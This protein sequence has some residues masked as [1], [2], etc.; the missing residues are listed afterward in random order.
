MQRFS[1]QSVFYLLA[2]EILYNERDTWNRM[3][4]GEEEAFRTIFH[5]YT[6][7][8]YAA[9]LKIVKQEETAREMV[10]EVFLK[11]WQ[12]REAI[13]DMEK[14]DGWLFRVASNLSLSFLRRQSVEF[15]WLNNLRQQ[16]NTSDDLL[17]SISFREAQQVLQQAIHALPEKRRL[18][19]RLSREEKLSHAEIAEKLN[20]S[21][22]TVKNQIVIAR[23]FVE[24]YFKTRF[25]IYLPLFVLSKIFF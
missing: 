22:N 3:A 2:G 14:P 7:A 24:D 16:E 25:G 23:Q 4:A 1:A 21:Q 8:L 10:Q 11:V 18:I 17:D 13:A 9:I 19:F 20:M 12:H 5:Q 6:P 15:K